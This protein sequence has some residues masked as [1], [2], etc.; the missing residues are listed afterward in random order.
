MLSSVSFSGVR[1]SS[2]SDTFVRAPDLALQKK[3][4]NVLVNEEQNALKVLELGTGSSGVKVVFEDSV[5][6]QLISL[7]LTSE[8]FT[9]LQDK[10]QNKEDYFQREDGSIRLN[11]EAGNFISSWFTDM[12]YGLNW[13]GAD[14][15]KDGI[16]RAG[17]LSNAYLHATQITLGDN[18]VSF[19][20]IGKIN[21]S[22][23]FDEINI[24]R[25]L[26]HRIM[27]DKNLDKE[28]SYDELYDDEDLALFA[29]FAKN[30]NSTDSVSANSKRKTQNL[31]QKVLEEGINSLSQQ[32]LVQFKTQYPSQYEKL[33]NFKEAFTQGFKQDL[34]QQFFNEG[35]KIIDLKA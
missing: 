25:G 10:F 13:L 27:D 24:E 12:A 3:S 29:D 4:Q 20:Y 19:S 1:F 6:N 14:S 11:G 35:L 2:L 26:N 31:L 9:R 5:S 33:Q 16:I 15:N 30:E 23:V 18:N 7:S 22:Y 32:E 8:N 28:I 17:E 34:L 21:A